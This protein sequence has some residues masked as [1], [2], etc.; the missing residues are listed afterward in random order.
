MNEGMTMKRTTGRVI[1]MAKRVRTFT[2]SHPSQEPGYAGWSVRLDAV[3][4]RA[5]A[6]IEQQKAGLDAQHSATETRRQL[7]LKLHKQLLPHL[8]TAGVAA[9]RE[10]PT[11]RMAFGLPRMTATGNVYAGAIRAMLAQVEAEAELF[12]RVGLSAS[13]V[14]DVTQTLA[15]FEAA[16]EEGHSAKAEHIAASQAFASVL[17]DVREVVALLDGFNRYRF[18]NDAALLAAWEGAKNVVGPFRGTEGMPP[19]NVAA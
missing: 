18:A 3:V 12:A 7:R 19:E 17:S 11:L 5:D 1:D 2:H 15:A 8:V 6:L 10:Q 14:V 13:L 9:A 16:L 4:E